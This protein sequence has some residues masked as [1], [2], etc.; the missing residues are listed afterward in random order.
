MT[1]GRF[2]DIN[3]ALEAEIS[4]PEGGW[5]P[6]F[7]LANLLSEENYVGAP[8][9]CLAATDLALSRF[10]IVFPEP[11]SP[12]LLSIFFHTMSLGARYRVTGALE[13]ASY[14][15]PTLATGWQWVYPS[16]YDPEELDFGVENFLAGTV[17]L[18]ELDLLKRHMF[19]PLAE[20]LVDRLLVELDDQEH[21]DGFFDVG[22]VHV[23][24]GL[25]P[26]INFDR[27]REL[28]VQPRDLVDEAPS[29]RRFADRRPPR[30]VLSVSYS[31]LTDPEARRFIDAAMRARSVGT[32]VFVPNLDDPTA[33]LREA[34]PANFGKTPSAGISWPGLAR[35]AFTLEEILA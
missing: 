13:D 35:V 15:A 16:I 27:G 6:A 30:R 21:P 5:S 22:G 9:R 17:T 26:L 18:D 3:L 11:C 28:S 20:S 25:S 12:T 34:F 29:G 31:N 1:L 32:V 14:T 23:A 4:G 33:T 8:A 24:A 10:E 2:T 19:A 7:P